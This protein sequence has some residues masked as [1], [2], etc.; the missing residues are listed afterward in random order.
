MKG[1]RRLLKKLN[2]DLDDDEERR[3]D[4]H[5]A[6]IVTAADRSKDFMAI[7]RAGPDAPLRGDEAAAAAEAKKRQHRRVQSS[8]RSGLVCIAAL[9]V[10]LCVGGLIALI[11]WAAVS[12]SDAA[13]TTT[14]TTVAP[15]SVGTTGDVATEAP[16]ATLPVVSGGG[17]DPIVELTLLCNHVLTGDDEGYCLAVFSYDNPSGEVVTVLHG[18]DNYIE[19]GPHN[20]G[21][22]EVFAA[23]T[24]FG[25]AAVRWNCASHLH[26]R[27]TLTSGGASSVATAPRTHLEC[28][29]LPL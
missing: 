17:G 19:P 4:K 14:T 16:A 25:G 10:L 27:W 13:S 5:V 12:S 29:P 22:P 28:P 15:V 26:A 23:G 20:R 21:Q 11:I 6:K 2:F 24:R 7:T 8:G 3:V 18:A 9:L 1:E